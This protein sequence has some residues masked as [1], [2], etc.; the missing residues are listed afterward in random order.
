MLWLQLYLIGSGVMFLFANR[1]QTPKMSQYDQDNWI[2]VMGVSI[3]WP[4]FLI[5]K[6]CVYLLL[7]I[8]DGSLQKILFYEIK[9]KYQG[10]APSTSIPV[11]VTH[12]SVPRGAARY[13]RETYL[14]RA[15][16]LGPRGHRTSDQGSSIYCV[17][18]VESQ[19]VD[20]EDSEDSEET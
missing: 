3:L 2:E 9:P 6:F 17:G 12:H 11:S 7:S 13:R 5:C 19:M 1:E 16:R 14:E 18:I 10:D 4:A 20:H 15:E 8:E